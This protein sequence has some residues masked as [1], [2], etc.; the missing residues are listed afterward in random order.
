MV[1]PV[2]DSASTK[3]FRIDFE[4]LLESLRLNIVSLHNN[5]NA[6]NHAEHP[7]LKLSTVTQSQALMRLLEGENNF[8]NRIENMKRDVSHSPKI[9]INEM[10]KNFDEL[11]SDLLTVLQDRINEENKPQTGPGMFGGVKKSVLAEILETSKTQINKN[12]IMR[13]GSSIKIDFA[14]NPREILAQS[15]GSNRFRR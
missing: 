13:E 5:L 1:F 14:I 8:I 3:Q 10:I 7:E 11:K 4:T 6:Q 12:T 15:P 9:S 2:S